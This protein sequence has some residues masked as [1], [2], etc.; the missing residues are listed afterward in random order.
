LPTKTLYSVH[1]GVAMMQK[2]VTDLPAK[3]G[4]SLD[5]WIALVEAVGPP[6]EKDRR[7]WLKVTHG[8]GTNASWWIAE[9]SVG[10]GYDDSDPEAYLPARRATK[11]DPIA[12]LKCE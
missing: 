8:L 1:P 9:R 4:R 3:T 10:K 5:E 6:A 12:A 7:E 2:W 11:V